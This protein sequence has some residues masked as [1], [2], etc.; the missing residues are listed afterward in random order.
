LRLPDDVATGGTAS[1]T[2]TAP[3]SRSLLGGSP[4]NEDIAARQFARQQ[5]NIDE[6]I[7][8]LMRLS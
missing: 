2:P 4:A 3:V 1:V 6:E 8:R 7:S 5:P